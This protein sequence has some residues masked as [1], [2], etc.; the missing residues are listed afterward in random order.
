VGGDDQMTT[1]PERERR[2]RAQYKNASVLNARMRVYKLFSTNPESVHRWIFGQLQ[3]P[4]GS[5]IL[6]LG[7]GKGDLWLENRD[8]IPENW[9][10]ILSDFSPGMLRETQAALGALVQR[11]RFAV[12]DAREIPFAAGSFDAV[13]ANHMLYHIKPGRQRVL[14]EI[15]RVLQPEGRLYAST[16]G[17]SK[18]GGL[19]ALMARFN[20]RTPKPRQATTVGGMPD[21]FYLEDGGEQ[22]APWFAD[23]AVRR[24]ENELLVTEAEPL[25]ASAR[26]RGKLD[27]QQLAAFAEY[28]EAEISQHRVIRLAKEVGLFEARRPRSTL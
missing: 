19:G 27:E 28:V 9:A 1:P 15:A 11:F 12:V 16:N 22:L 2:L 14:A 17:R 18:G 8:R 24:Y 26:T 6:E 7:C 10:V 4:P 25:I 20:P 13:V 5:Q 23:I 3:L 21:T